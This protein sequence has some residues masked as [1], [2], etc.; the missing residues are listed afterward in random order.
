M[1]DRN[2][3]IDTL[4]HR[5]R[6][7]VPYQLDL[8]EEMR[9]KVDQELGPDFLTA[10]ENCLAINGDGKFENLDGHRR[11]DQFGAVW[12]LDQKGDFGVVENTLLPEPTCDSYTFPE[13]DEEAI[14]ETC[15][16]LVSSIDEG[17]FAMFTIGFSLFERAWTLRGMENILADMVLNPAFLDELMERITAYNL[18]VIDIVLEYPVDALF[19]GDDWGQQK[20][21]IMGPG[22]W[23]RFIKPGLVKMYRR[24]KEGGKYI[25]QHSCGDIQEVFPDLIDLGLDIY[26]T[27]QPEIYDV[28]AVKRMYGSS[29]S[30]YGGISTQRVLPFGTAAEV[31]NE[32]RQMMQIVGNGGGY[33]VA[34]THAMPPDIPVE[35]LLAFLEVVQ[36]Q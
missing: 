20:G 2:L 21:L 16:K 22:Y 12:L 34:P 36:A 27:F 14:R 7:A 6:E 26:N 19:F 30:F 4:Q 31:R 9:A 24:V 10:V 23:R 3:V 8:T 25:C 11:K 1:N 15:R 28:Q 35:N 13:P 18:A 29:L 5:Q 17:K 32:T 33:I